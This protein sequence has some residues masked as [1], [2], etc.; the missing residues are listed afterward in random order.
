MIATRR[1]FLSA[2]LGLASLAGLGPLVGR[3]SAA[4]VDR[5]GLQLYTVRQIFQ[6]DP[7]GTLEKVRKAGYTQVEF[8]GGGFDAM[9]PA[10]LRKAMDRFGLTAPSLHVAYDLLLNDFDKAL[11]MIRTLGAETAVLPHLGEP[12]RNAP[13]WTE[14]VANFNRFAEKLKKAGIGF[15]YHNHDFEFLVKPDGVSLWDRLIKD[16]DAALVRFE[17]DLYWAIKAGQDPKAMIRTLGGQIYSYHV[18]DMTPDG[19]MAAVG[20][21]TID[22]ASIFKLDSVAGVQRY[23]VENDQAPAPYIPDIT[24]SFRNLRTLLASG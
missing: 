21:G 17:L 8:G 20:T 2:S 16:R 13:A 9:D 18:K 14:A 24:T 10:M 15:A 6:S 7:V 22:F 5:I 3:A 12:F 23:Y 4:K 11:A 1:T 19:R